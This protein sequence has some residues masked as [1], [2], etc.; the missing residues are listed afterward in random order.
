MATVRTGNKRI[1]CMQVTTVIPAYN[2][3]SYLASAIESALLQ[4]GVSQQIV[5]VD[6]GSTDD[7]PSVL[8]RF[9]D[10]I[11]TIR[12]SNR[13]LS[14][15]RNAGIHAAKGKYVAFLDADDLWVPG[16]LARQVAALEIN[17]EAAMLHSQTVSWDPT[18]GIERPFV[19]APSRDY[20]GAC[21]S[22]LF[23]ANA[24]CVSSVIARTDWL[25][26]LGGFDEQIVRPTTQ[27]YDLWLRIAFE[28][29]ILFIEEKGTRY[30]RHASN[31]S[32]QHQMM[33]ED[34]I[35][36]IRKTLSYG[37]ERLK[38][39]IGRQTAFLRL[40][41]LYHELGYWHYEQGEIGTARDCFRSSCRYGRLDPRNLMFAFLPKVLLM[42]AARR[43]QS[44]LSA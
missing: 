5:V 26:R 1:L 13:G 29:P 42:Y 25:Q 12:Q 43:H 34:H 15:A 20:R 40:A 10:R 18:T 33:L 35:F 8:E 38:R 22:R 24:I 31:A 21:F 4:E 14:A 7:T 39:E 9:G 36:V 32:L 6:D 16:K 23:Q 28:S 41:N 44:K 17:P 11:E 27:D 3:S 2:A 19:K 37:Y 30:R